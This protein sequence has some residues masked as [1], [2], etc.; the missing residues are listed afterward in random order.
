M[1]M[2]AEN[3]TSQSR[4]PVV[5]ISP[6]LP[7]IA[8]ECPSVIDPWENFTPTIG[9]FTSTEIYYSSDLYTD[10]D[11]YPRLHTPVSTSTAIAIVTSKK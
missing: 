11:G 8:D 3:L 5:N 4:P 7:D 6:S 10:K 2:T 9:T 1:S